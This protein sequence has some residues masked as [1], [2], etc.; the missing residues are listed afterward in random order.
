MLRGAHFDSAAAA[1]DAN[2]IQTL[3]RCIVVLTWHW[4]ELL[5][6][7]SLRLTYGVDASGVA[8]ESEQ[9]GASIL[10]SSHLMPGTCSLT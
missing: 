9:E 5:N 6:W 7:Y 1:V 10:I 8:T 4:M 3:S 2:R